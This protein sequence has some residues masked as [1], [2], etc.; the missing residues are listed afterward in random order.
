MKTVL[1]I[2]P[3]Q[4]NN[5]VIHAMWNQGIKMKGLRHQQYFSQIDFYLLAEKMLL[6]VWADLWVCGH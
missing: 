3:P 4:S 1:C 2:I 6:R 5:V